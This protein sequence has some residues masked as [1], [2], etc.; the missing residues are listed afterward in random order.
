MH[1]I[2]ERRRKKYHRKPVSIALPTSLLLREFTS[3][4]DIASKMPRGTF[5]EI[6][7]QGSN[8]PST[9]KKRSKSIQNDNLLRIL[10]IILQVII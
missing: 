10:K 1:R 3:S 4:Q 8:A 6:S 9:R 7:T 2:E 5:N